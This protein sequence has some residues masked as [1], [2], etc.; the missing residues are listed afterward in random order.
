[1]IIRLTGKLGRKLRISPSESLPLSSNPYTD[2]SANLFTVK[3]YQ[4]ILAVNTPSLY[5]VLFPGRGVASGSDL[6]ERM[7]DELKR[8]LLLDGYQFI[9]DRII[10][11]H[12][13]EISFSKSYSRTVTGSMTEMMKMA[14]LYLG[15]D[16]LDP[17]DVA[18]H[19]N[20][21]IMNALENMYPRREFVSENMRDL[22]G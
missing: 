13:G 8:M 20:G 6:L 4:Y 10:S 12:T 21:T 17:F 11:S 2:W 16:E 14:K 1:M 3:R 9:M 15:E 19:L 7:T 5:N 22:Y 18:V